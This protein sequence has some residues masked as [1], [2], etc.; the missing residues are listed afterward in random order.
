M[1]TDDGS[2]PDVEYKLVLCMLPIYEK[3]GMRIDE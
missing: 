1:M 2:S 3:D